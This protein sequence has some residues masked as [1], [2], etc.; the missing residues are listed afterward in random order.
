MV[1]QY[2]QNPLNS[3]LG[4]ILICP[5]RVEAGRLEDFCLFVPLKYAFSFKTSCSPT[6]S[7][8]R[9]HRAPC[10][11]FVKKTIG[12][13][14]LPDFIDFIL[15][16]CNRNGFDFQPEFVR[17]VFDVQPN[18]DLS[19]HKN[20]SDDEYPLRLEVVMPQI[21]C[22][23]SGICISSKTAEFSALCL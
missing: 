3:D 16:Q 18:F 9:F 11:W 13:Q 23:K 15:C 10:S 20:T 2:P 19:V 14:C 4:V 12:S 21:S 1:V 5:D 22:F 6:F 7:V 17:P 8:P